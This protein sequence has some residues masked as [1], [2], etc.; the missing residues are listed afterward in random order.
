MTATPFLLS[1]L[2]YSPPTA[3]VLVE[4]DGYM[5]PQN[6]SAKERRVRAVKQ[7]NDLDVI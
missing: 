5:V 6:C 2:N 7:L 1:N 3:M 4:Y